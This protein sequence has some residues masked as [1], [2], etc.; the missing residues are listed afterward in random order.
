[1]PVVERESIKW[2]DGVL[3]KTNKQ[4]NNN[5]NN[6]TK[7]KTSDPDLFLSK[8]TA[9]TKMEKSLMERM[10]SDRLKLGSISRGGSKLTLLLMLWCS[11]KKGLIITALKKAQQAAGRVRCRY[12]H[13]INGQKLLTPVV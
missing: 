11:H 9:G 8:R 13:P 12:L 2:R 5:N 4:T 10:S 1:L 3:R 6:K 7:T